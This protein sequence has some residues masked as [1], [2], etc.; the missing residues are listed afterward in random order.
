MQH[1]IIKNG[2]LFKYTLNRVNT[3]NCNRYIKTQE[4]YIKNLI[5][6][7]KITKQE[8]QASL[9]ILRDY[10]KHCMHA[11]L[12]VTKQNLTTGEIQHFSFAITS[13]PKDVIILPSLSEKLLGE[14]PEMY[15]VIKIK[16]GLYITSHSI[17][18]AWDLKSEQLQ[19]DEN[20]DKYIEVN[21]PNKPFDITQG[22]LEKMADL[23]V[24]NIESSV[25][26]KNIDITSMGDLR[27]DIVSYKMLELM[28]N[29]EFEKETY[30]EIS[31]KMDLIDD[32]FNKLEEEYIK[33]IKSSEPTPFD[34]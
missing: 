2:N 21:K 24:T 33:F 26:I 22:D 8:Q 29:D 18:N 12:N 14:T 11:T 34:E 4:G 23:V 3:N 1:V 10:R 25:G 17:C 19:Y 9:N 32:K 30:Q 20:A 16:D 13:K 7:D 27:N 5:K 6:N 28:K 31:H 15:N